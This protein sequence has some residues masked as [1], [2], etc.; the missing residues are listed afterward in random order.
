MAR[1]KEF[2]VERALDAAVQLFWE[3]GYEATCLREL[4]DRMGIGRQSL[5]DTFG[6]KRQL[7]LRAL[8]RYTAQGMDRLKAQLLDP[9]ATL[10]QLRAFLESM[11]EAQTARGPRRGCLVASTILE[12][13]D[14]DEAIAQT[15][16]QHER[17]T[18]RA[19]RDLLERAKR[20][21][22]VKEDLDPGAAATFVMGQI[23]GITVL[24][25]NGASRAA[26]REMVGQ[27]MA[28]F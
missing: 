11:V 23:Y 15:C 16:R 5:Y 6:D 26:L 9:Q 12:I 3:K 7:F 1:A 20:K 25:R 28:T 21:G 24:A 13:G 17:H 22:E 2:D 4:E 27:A 10:P 19:I 14:G 18:R 8:D